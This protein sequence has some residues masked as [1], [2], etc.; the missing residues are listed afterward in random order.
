MMAAYGFC[1]RMVN[2]L[3]AHFFVPNRRLPNPHGS[4]WLRRLDDGLAAGPGLRGIRRRG[5]LWRYAVP[6][7]RTLPEA[8]RRPAP[9]DSGA[10]QA[11][12]VTGRCFRSGARRNGDV[13]VSVEKGGSPSNGRRPGPLAEE[14][15]DARDDGEWRRMRCLAKDAARP[16]RCP[17]RFSRPAR[18]NV[19]GGGEVRLRRLSVRCGRADATAGRPNRGAVPPEAALRPAL[20]SLRRRAAPP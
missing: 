10:W 14:L 13:F 2:T 11:G 17:G 9:R 12:S 7:P 8:G 5:D 4:S 3:N 15:A 6:V 18:M 20:R 1:G 16:G 19:A